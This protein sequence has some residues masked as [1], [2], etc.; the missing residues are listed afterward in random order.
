MTTWHQIKPLAH[1]LGES[2]CHMSQI[3][4]T[5]AKEVTHQQDT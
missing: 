4:Q 5:S 3:A 2:P 1:K